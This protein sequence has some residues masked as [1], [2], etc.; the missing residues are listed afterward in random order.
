[1]RKKILSIVLVTVVFALLMAS[2]SFVIFSNGA[3]YEQIKTNLKNFTQYLLNQDNVDEKLVD[4]FKINNYKVRCTY[5]KVDGTVI[6]DNM[7]EVEDNH[8]NRKEIIE[9]IKDGEGYAVRISDTT[10]EKLVYYAVKLD[11]NNILRVSVPYTSVS[12]FNSLNS[13]Y[14]I[15]FLFIIIIVSVSLSMR[16]MSTIIKPLKELQSVTNR[17]AKGDLHIR[18][19]VESNDEIGLLGLTFNNMADQLQSKINEVIDKQN[20]LESILSSMQSGVIAVNKRDEVITINPYAKKVLGI[21]N[22][23]PGE[24]ISQYVKDYDIVEFLNQDKDLEKEIKVLYPSARELKIKK[25]GLVTGKENI[26]KVIA[27]HDITDIKKLENMRSE[28]VA[29]VSH[30]LKTPLTS[31][32]GFSET[33]KYVDD[34]ET[35][36]KFLNI[37]NKEAERLSRLITDI[38][39]L[40]KLE[41]GSHNDFLPF[42]P[43][44]VI[45]DVVNMVKNMYKNKK[46]T[47]NIDNTCYSDISCDKDK[48]LQLML[49]LVENAVKY[50][51]ED[52]IVDIKSYVN[53]D[54]YIIEV[55][56]NGIGIPEEDIPRIFERFYRVDKSRKGGSTGLGLAIVKHIVKSYDGEIYVESKLN[57][58]T[59]FTVQF[60][61]W[62]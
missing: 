56:D 16:I 60:N 49:N 29:N 39:V 3:E 21:K 14:S 32:K 59:K 31:I 33:L 58:G 18:V 48:F 42:K 27:I 30:E 22:Y 44:A 25:A 6:F 10:K 2:I 51:N 41:S 57:E 61:L 54:K 34:K 23:V 20:R 17:I 7:T 19:K 12:L 11:N 1:M 5:I 36:D 38:L 40:S 8:L 24:H 35:R 26:G 9:A 15:V 47:I 43:L 52:V 55:K 46:V 37:I 4:N 45:E 53:E 62:E 50:S 28:F 13:K